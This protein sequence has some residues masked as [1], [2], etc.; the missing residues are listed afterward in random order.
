MLVESDSCPFVPPM[1]L[2][3][4]HRREHRSEQCDEY[5]HDELPQELLL[6]S[7]VSNIR[8]A[9]PQAHRP[10]SSQHH[11]PECGSVEYIRGL[12]GVGC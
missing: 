3:V 7:V 6:L 11:A 8:T 5:V 10:Q 4:V 2:C 12:A 1:C 9:R